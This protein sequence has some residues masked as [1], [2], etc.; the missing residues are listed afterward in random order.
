MGMNLQEFMS[1]KILG[2]VRSGTKDENDRPKKLPH[3]D[4][5]IDRST[6]SLA[7]EIFNE[8]YKKP[9]KLKIKLINQNPFE[10]FLERYEGKKRKCYGNGKEAKQINEKGK[11]EII[12]CEGNDCPYRDDKQCKI[13]GKLYF[14]ID[15]LQDEG[16]WC[17]PIGSEKGVRRIGARIARANR[18]G[19]DLT[20]DWYELF[21]TPVDAPTTGINYIPDIRKIESSNQKSDN[22]KKQETPNNSN[23][24]SN[25][26]NPNYLKV[27]GFLMTLYENK[28][29]PKIKFIDTSSKER[30]LI[31]LPGG[32]QEILKV[33][34]GS[35][36]LPL[37]I[38]T[39]NNVSILNDYKIVKT[40][41]ED[42]KK[43][44]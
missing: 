24:K 23:N 22:P 28:K 11:T 19:E 42:N 17:Y 37:S 34:Q 3:F 6:S 13:V 30:E 32:K 10:V 36:I 25:Q 8:A 5:H 27:M 2:N 4:V 21:L 9:N 44:S 16:I 12:Q 39:R 7:V 43:A 29:V 35:I 33:Q 40:V 31:L 38:S 18:K 41:L 14:Y 26:N 1:D 15:K 20:K